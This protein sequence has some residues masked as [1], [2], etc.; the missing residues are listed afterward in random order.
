MGP[1]SKAVVKNE[2]TREKRVYKV[3]VKIA[4]V[5][6][7]LKI[8]WSP[9]AYLENKN[10]ASRFVDIKVALGRVFSVDAGSS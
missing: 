1:G 8:F 5:S 6:S 4:L 10:L 7:K 9:I 2:E 3:L